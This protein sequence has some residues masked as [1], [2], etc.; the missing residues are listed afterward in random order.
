[1]TFLPRLRWLLRLPLN[2]QKNPPATMTLC[3]KLHWPF[4]QPLRQQ[5][6]RQ[7]PLRLKLHRHFLY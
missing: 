6:L 3:P 7:Q 5:P 2:L 1:M 4:H